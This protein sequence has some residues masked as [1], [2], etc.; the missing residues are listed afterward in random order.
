MITNRQ[1]I[2]LAL[3]GVRLLNVDFLAAMWYTPVQTIIGAKR[4]TNDLPSWGEAEKEEIQQ[5]AWLAEAA[6]QKDALM[7]VHAKRTIPKD[8]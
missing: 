8:I 4:S 1:A 2:E 5:E 6:R 3:S 7:A